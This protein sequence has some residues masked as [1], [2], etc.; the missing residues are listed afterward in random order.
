MILW[1][2][3][4]IVAVAGEMRLE[5]AIPLLMKRVRKEKV[6]DDAFTALERI[7]NDAVV[8]ALDQKWWDA[9]Q[10]TRCSYAILL[11]DIHTDESV[12]KCHAFLAGEEDPEVQLLLANS[13]LGNYETD[14]IDLCW[15]LV[16]D[17]DEDDLAPDQRDLRYRLVA[18]ATIMG[19]K[20]P[21]FD[22]WRKAALRDNWGKFTAE[23]NRLAD[24]F[25]PDMPGPK[26]SVN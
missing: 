4:Q 13:L 21:H 17:M 1:V 18:I 24:A 25:K 26:W 7:G 9:D 8:R 19:K 15:P 6:M 22:E 20:F 12:R 16:A 3:P 14:A 23:H 5:E 11:E 10:D 2:E